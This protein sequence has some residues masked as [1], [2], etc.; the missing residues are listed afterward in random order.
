MRWDRDRDPVGRPA[1]A[2]RSAAM[3]ARR[4]DGG[5]EAPR[6]GAELTVVDADELYDDVDEPHWTGLAVHGDLAHWEPDGLTVTG[7]RLAGAQLTGARLE[8]AR[9]VDVVFDGCELSGTVL[10]RATFL[11]VEFR[12]CRAVGSVWSQ[13]QLRHVRI[14]GC[15]LDRSHWNELQAERL[16]V[17]GSLFVEADLIGARVPGARFDGCDL[18]LADASGATFTGAHLHGSR[19]DGL[20]GV[21]GL[22]GAHVDSFQ[23][24]A[25]APLF[26]ADA[27]I[28]VDD[29]PGEGGS[30]D[31][32]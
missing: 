13:A 29:P 4:D 19:L 5:P 20:K 1:G 27:G 26:L 17:A 25:L 16:H 30:H 8:R 24:L 3:A 22:A 2:V 23:V 15:K 12:Q 11:R 7:C 9:F 10:E 32:R 6:L 21:R 31:H 18:T 28:V 14:E